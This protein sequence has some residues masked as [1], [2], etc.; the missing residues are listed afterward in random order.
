[1]YDHMPGDA[2]GTIHSAQVRPIVA[3]SDW[4]DLALRTGGTGWPS[5]RRSLDPNSIIHNELCV[6]R[7]LVAVDS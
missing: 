7:S 3:G 5:A 6:D 4:R 1:M 2:A